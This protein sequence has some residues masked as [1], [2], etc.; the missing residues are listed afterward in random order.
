MRPHCCGH[1][2]ADTNVSPFPTCATFVVDTNFVSGTQKMFLIL[3]RNI[4]CRQQMFPSLH[5]P[6]NIMRNNVS[7]TM[8]PGLLR[9]LTKNNWFASG[10]LKTRRYWLFEIVDPTWEQRKFQTVA[11][12]FP[13]GVKIVNA[14]K[15]L[16]WQKKFPCSPKTEKPVL[17]LKNSY[18]V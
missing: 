1:I 15:S 4:L 12:T 6:R 17:H 14:T 18:F 16:F 5:S 11:A 13:R 10:A 8:C 3:F 2:V 7:A 9:P